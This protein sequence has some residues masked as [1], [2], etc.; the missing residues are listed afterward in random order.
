MNVSLFQQLAADG[1]AGSAFEQ[2]VVRQNHGSSPMLLKN[3]EDVL[4]EVE[5]FVSRRR[6]EVIAVDGERFA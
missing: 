3:R 1:F 4:Q 6:P 5:L 2:H